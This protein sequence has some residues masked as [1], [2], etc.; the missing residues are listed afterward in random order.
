MDSERLNKEKILEWFEQWIG[1][2]KTGVDYVEVCVR[3]KDFLNAQE[4]E[5]MFT[6]NKK[7]IAKQLWREWAKI[8]K[9]DR[10][11]FEEWLDQRSK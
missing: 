11:T 10:P 8:V 2:V 1:Q 5:D 4:S 6:I 9:F 7:E 3:A